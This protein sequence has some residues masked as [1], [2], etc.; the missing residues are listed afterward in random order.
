MINRSQVVGL[1]G[2]TSY[3]LVY[4]FL[5]FSA[6]GGD[7]GTYIFFA[8]AGPY[9]LG[10]LWFPLAGFLA[11]DLRPFLSKV[12]FISALIVHYAIIIIFLRAVWEIDFPYFAQVWDNSPS[13]ILLPAG[14]YLLGQAIIWA[15][16]I[17][18]VVFESHRAS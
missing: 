8:P 7:R 11:G 17:R 4:C 10:L 15:V 18:G 12:V 14:W 6:T 1:A 2:G 16:F 13:Y 5:A 3:G 9:L